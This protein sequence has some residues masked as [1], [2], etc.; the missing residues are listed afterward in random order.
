MIRQFRK[1]S[2][3]DRKSIGSS[4]YKNLKL[5]KKKKKK[6]KNSVGHQVPRYVPKHLLR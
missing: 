2:F 5:K 1:F 4:K 6:K 3:P